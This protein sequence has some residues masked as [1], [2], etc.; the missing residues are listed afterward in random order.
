MVGILSLQGDFE[1]HKN[2]LDK[3]EVD[4]LYVKNKEDL[5]QTRAL[6][7]PGGESTTLSMLIDRFAM[8]DALCDYA[9]SH[10]IFGTCAGMIMLSSKIVKKDN[11]VKAL[12][13]MDFSVSRNSWGSQIDSFEREIDLEAFEIRSFNAIFIRAPKV[14]KIGEGIN[15]IGYIDEDEAVIL[16]DGTHMVSSFHP[17]L[18]E[19]VRLHEYFLNKFY[20]GKE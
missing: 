17:E 1:K 2:I 12:N 19:D 15:R 6:I 11:N 4:S 18:E 20:Y 14:D 13:V 9:K 16:E 7:I 10:S 8:R 5:R 3:L